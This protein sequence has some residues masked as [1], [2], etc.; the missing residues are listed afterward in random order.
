[1]KEEIKL[2]NEYVKNY[3]LKNKK[4]IGKYHHSFR[5]MEFCKEI[6]ISLNLNEE[7]ISIASLCGLLHDIARFEQLTKYDTYYDF[8]SF[9]HGD[10]G[11]DILEHDD[12]IKKFTSDEEIIKI[13]LD[14]VRYHNKFKVPNLNERNMLFVNILRDADKIDIMTEWANEIRDNKIILKESIL[15]SIYNKE[16]CKKSDLENDTD[17]ILMNMS[18]IFDLNFKYSF[19]YLKNKKIIEKKFNLLEMYGE[20]KEISE[21]KQFIMK[22]IG[23]KLC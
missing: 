13:V 20:T 18:W 22:E 1:M 4:L 14:G 9:D 10:Y 5:V 6:A 21:L 12:F 3:D 7:D 19:E 17:N 8:K 2:F 11:C 15:K 16:L 23:E